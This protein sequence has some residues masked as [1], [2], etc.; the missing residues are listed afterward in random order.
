MHGTYFDGCPH[1][2]EWHEQLAAWN[3]DPK[4]KYKDSTGFSMMT[5]KIKSTMLHGSPHS[6]GVMLVHHTTAGR[7]AAFVGHYANLTHATVIDVVGCLSYMPDAL[8]FGVALKRVT[9]REEDELRFIIVVK[10]EGQ[11]TIAEDGGRIA[12]MQKGGGKGK[13]YKNWNQWQ[14]EDKKEEQKEDEVWR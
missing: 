1:V 11:H 4:N 13:T 3:E 8:C 7:L 5:G 10:V 9:G 12:A 6:V 2:G 14:K